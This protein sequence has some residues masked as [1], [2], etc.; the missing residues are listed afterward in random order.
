MDEEKQTYDEWLRKEEAQ[1][2][3]QLEAALDA[4]EEE[5]AAAEQRAAEAEGHVRAL[6]E[7]DEWLMTEDGMDGYV[8][9][10]QWCNNEKEHGHMPDC[11]RQAAVK[12]LEEHSPHKHR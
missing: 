10:C 12:W 7:A 6:L 8:D 9:Y 5:L 2:I 1:K 11:R 3:P 4:S